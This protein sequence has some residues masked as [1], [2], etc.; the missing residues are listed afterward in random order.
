MSLQIA[1]NSPFVNSNVNLYSIQ[2]H[3]HRFQKMNNTTTYANIKDNV[4]SAVIM[5]EP[6]QEFTWFT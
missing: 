2:G 5:A 6:L 1:T 3:H 4:Y